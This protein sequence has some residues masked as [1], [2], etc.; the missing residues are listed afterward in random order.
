MRPLGLRQS[1]GYAKAITSAVNL[2]R[3]QAH[4]R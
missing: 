2:S 1:T 3:D 4:G